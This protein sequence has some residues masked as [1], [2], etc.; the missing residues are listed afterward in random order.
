MHGNHEARALELGRHED[1]EAE[2]TSPDVSDEEDEE[3]EE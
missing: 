1:D 3:D 2:F